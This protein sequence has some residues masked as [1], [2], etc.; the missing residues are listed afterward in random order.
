MGIAVFCGLE[1]RDWGVKGIPGRDSKEK[2]KKASMLISSL[3]DQHEA[4]AV[5]MKRLH[6]SRSSPNLNRIVRKIKELCRKNKVKL[7][8]YSIKEL[9]EFFCPEVR[10][11]RRELA[12][13]VA[14]EYPVL[15]YELNREKA[16]RNPYHVRMFEAVALGSMYLHQ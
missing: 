11:N 10:I 3:I 14:S 9:E 5:A 8:Q 2:T 12:E 15:Y 13:I 16:H 1:L 7:H 6:P 4:N